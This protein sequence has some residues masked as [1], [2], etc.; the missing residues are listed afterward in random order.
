MYLSYI[1]SKG[2]RAFGPSKSDPR[3]NNLH[4]DGHRRN[5]PDIAHGDRDP[6][7]LRATA[8]EAPRRERAEPPR[9]QVRPDNINANDHPDGRKSQE[10]GKARDVP[11]GQQKH[12]EPK[13]EHV[14]PDHRPE[15]RRPD[16]RLPVHNRTIKIDDLPDGRQ[17]HVQEYRAS[18]DLPPEQQKPH[19]KPKG[20]GRRRFSEL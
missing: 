4:D 8:P 2:R 10:Y 16:Y 14:R 19:S 15:H 18:R 7:D 9:R 6:R 3:N 12:A 11:P 17:S 20:E 5:P 1:R 13:G